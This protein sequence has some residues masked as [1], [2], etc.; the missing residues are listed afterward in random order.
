MASSGS[1][2]NSFN[3]NTSANDQ[4]FPD[5]AFNG[6]YYLVAWEDR[7]GYPYHIYYTTVTPGGA[8]T[9]SSGIKISNKD[10]SDFHRAAAVTSNGHD[11][12]VTWFGARTN[13]DAVLVSRLNTSGVIIDTVPYQISSDTVLGNQTAAASN[14][15]DY[16]V[17]W[18]SQVPNNTYGFGL[19]FR[20]I[21][22]ELSLIDTLPVLIAYDSIGIFTPRVSYGGGCYLMTWQRNDDIYA[23]RILSDGTVLDLNGFIVCAD[24]G[25]QVDPT[26]A[27]DGHRFLVTWTDARTGNYDIY[28]VFIDSLANV[29]MVESLT[30]PINNSF[31]V[32]ISPLPF[33]DRVKIRFNL[34]ASDNIDLKIFNSSGRLVKSF[35]PNAIGGQPQAVSNIIWDGKDNSGNLLPQG[36]YFCRIS[37]DKT[38]IT[39]RI[40]KIQ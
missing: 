19:Y 20:R 25:Q 33:T 12:L 27:S 30:N 18:T 21:S 22:S 7:R 9:S 29:G 34:P 8:I 11:F 40:I 39:K 10:P 2:I 37:A 26:V 1:V 3:I 6:Q 4:M 16:L 31:A 32:N 14:G 17:A 38:S 24:T 15:E 5:I 13:G 35:Y 23:C 36:T 28:G